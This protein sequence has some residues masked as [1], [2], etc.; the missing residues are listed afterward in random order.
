MI[1]TIL[2]FGVTTGMQRVPVAQ[3]IDRQF[4]AFC[5]WGSVSGAKDEAAMYAAN[6]ENCGDCWVKVYLDC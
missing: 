2:D 5:R 1:T 3:N 6:I 4:G